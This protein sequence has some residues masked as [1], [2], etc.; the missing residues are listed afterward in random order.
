LIQRVIFP[1]NSG[2]MTGISSGDT[3]PNQTAN[4]GHV[5]EIPDRV[6][7]ILASPSARKHTVFH[8]AKYFRSPAD[9]FSFH[10][11]PSECRLAIEIQMEIG[12]F[13]FRV[14]YSG[15]TWLNGVTRQVRRIKLI[16][17]PGMEFLMNRELKLNIL[18]V[19]ACGALFAA[20]SAL[21]TLIFGAQSLSWY[22]FPTAFHE[23][24][25]GYEWMARIPAK[26]PLAVGIL[27]AA[28]AVYILTRT[29]NKTYRIST[30]LHPVNGI[31]FAVSVAFLFGAGLLVYEYDSGVG[32]GMYV[33]AAMAATIW[34]VALGSRRF[35]GGNKRHKVLRWAVFAVV[36]CGLE[37]LIAYLP[38]IG[39]WFS[40]TSFIRGVFNGNSYSYGGWL[41]F[42]NVNY[43]DF[44]NLL[45]SGAFVGGTAGLF[46]SDLGWLGDM[47]RHAWAGA[48]W[49]EAGAG[50]F[51]G[52][53]AGAI[54]ALTVFFGLMC[55]NQAPEIAP[56]SDFGFDFSKTR[57]IFLASFLLYSMVG[58]A[59]LMFFHS[60]LGSS[61]SK[62][63]YLSFTIALL[64]SG[65]LYYGWTHDLGHTKEINSKTTSLAW[66]K[67]PIKHD[68]LIVFVPGKP[69]V[70][71][72]TNANWNALNT[73]VVGRP[74]PMGPIFT[75]SNVRRAKRLIGNRKLMRGNYYWEVMNFLIL[76]AAYEFDVSEELK[77]I[78]KECRGVGEYTDNSV[79]CT[80]LA[81]RLKHV[82][83]TP[84]TVALA[85]RLSDPRQYHIGKYGMARMGAAFRHQGRAG[86]AEK[87]FRRADMAGTNIETIPRHAPT[88]FTGG[89]VRGR[90]LIDG[91]PAVGVRL[92]LVTDNSKK[93]ID[94]LQRSGS[95]RSKDL[96]AT[97]VTAPDGSFSFAG[98]GDDGEYTLA[99]VVP[100]EIVKPR[101]DAE[102]EETELRFSDN[103]GVIAVDRRHPVID[104]GDM[105]VSIVAR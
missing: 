37:V 3:I 78:D 14:T 104:M 2:D 10:I 92:A 83:V 31:K 69:L 59:C 89:S 7:G 43:P 1:E 12:I 80:I 60:A 67:K 56:N 65:S 64:L 90:F 21:G 94:A 97:A 41:G 103:P 76:N 25:R 15:R 93:T 57:F 88:A 70:L 68:T 54:A 77:W 50:I 98:I 16:G 30:L 85:D 22:I 28:V 101:A 102:W 71:D 48:G 29:V 44:T 51:R 8:S 52:A 87:W 47:E 34:I 99:A 11:T 19:V 5:P 95:F 35:F 100:L 72:R 105:S 38:R 46:F 79:S 18:A 74:S 17:V 6:P 24:F 27:A 62:R 63:K 23:K 4:S 91:R 39:A 32:M 55:V 13:Y 20:A 36:A 53:V 26:A 40:Y 81:G 96:S 49:R 84:E 9:F 73:S 58:A 33:A 82:A 42:F 86:E 66:D 75:A 61:A 45:S